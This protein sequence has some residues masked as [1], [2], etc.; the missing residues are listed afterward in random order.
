VVTSE[1]PAGDIVAVPGAQFEETQASASRVST[2]AVGEARRLPG[3]VG[4]SKSQVSAMAAEVEELM[5]SFRFRPPDAGP[6]AF[7]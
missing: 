5:E 2:P 4:L 3:I 7:V 6:Y 1:V